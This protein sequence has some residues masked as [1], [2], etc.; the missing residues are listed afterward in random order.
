MDALSAG[1]ELIG[2]TL[3]VHIIIVTISIGLPVLMSY[4]EWQAWRHKSHEYRRLTRLLA[5][6]AA[7][8]VV[9]GVFTGT[10]VAL[11]LSTLWAPFLD[12]VRPSVGVLFQLEGYM[13]LI[14]AVFL[15]WYL[16]TLNTIG[17]IKHFWI[18]LPISIGT[19]GSA[20][21]ITSVN[22]YMNNP[23]AIFTATTANEVMH[24]VASYLFSTTVLVLGYIA[25]RSLKKQTLV[26]QKFLQSVMLQL[27]VIAG[28]LLIA[29]AVL[30]HQSA[31]LLASTQ[32]HKLAA[33]EILDN[34]Q[35][36]APL[37]IGGMIDDSGKATGGIVL[38]GV[39]S[40]LVGWSTDTKVQGLNEIPRDQWPFLVV[41]TMFDIKMI[42]VGLSCA[43][44][45][46]VVWYGWR[47]HKQPRWLRIVLV[48]FSSIGFV[49]LELG[50]LI[51][52][53]GRQTWTVVGKLST[54]S[55]Y[56]L[57]A[58]IHRTQYL[59]I[60][61]FVLLGLTTTYALVYTTRRWRSEE[62][63]SW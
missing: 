52:E 61:L 43:I 41:H 15:S 7:V 39:L 53:F 58:N 42:L 63:Q 25:W 32:P 62:K 56:T 8:F 44:I 21:F 60:V 20:F 47:I 50:W 2:H 3:A 46:L 10:A 1:R 9:A 49:M 16:G 33:I 48:P 24:S 37:R 38:P 14:E 22:A 13:F 59:F 27:G 6:W 36:N 26:A 54:E 12:H 5:L 11:Q 28:L 34:T 35:T 4:F 55:A 31:V 57:G 51:T 17:S 30:G 19:I 40:W 29:L 45:L 23:E 18:G